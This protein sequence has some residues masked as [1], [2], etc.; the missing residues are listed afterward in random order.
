MHT[1]T[2]VTRNTTIDRCSYNDIY[3]N[4]IIS[5]SL[6]SLIETTISS[7]V[8]C[9]SLTTLIIN[10]NILFCRNMWYLVNENYEFL[11]QYIK[12][13]WCIKLFLRLQTTILYFVIVIWNENWRI[14]CPKVITLQCVVNMTYCCVV[15]VYSIN[16]IMSYN[17]QSRVCRIFCHHFAITTEK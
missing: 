14:V 4:V 6:Y 2:T 17:L 9:S 5:Y 1:N 13:N 15:Y 12:T 7:S 11:L 3:D 10:Q 8:I 16:S